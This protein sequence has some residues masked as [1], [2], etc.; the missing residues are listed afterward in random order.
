MPMFQNGV[1]FQNAC[2]CA[3]VGAEQASRPRCWLTPT[4]AW[5]GCGAAI[6]ADAAV[7]ETNNNP[8]RRGQSRPRGRCARVANNAITSFVDSQVV[9]V[10]TLGAAG[11]GTP[12]TWLAS[13]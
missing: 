1:L 3:T 11:S 2:I 6:G 5:A 4:E 10:L 8:V 12:D 13:V 9:H 7:S